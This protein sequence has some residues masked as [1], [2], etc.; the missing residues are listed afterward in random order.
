MAKV[1]FTISY[2]IQ[3]EKRDEYL[4][5]A[6]EMARHLAS[7]KGKNYSIYELKNK[8]NS[9]C[10]IFV[11]ASREEYDQLE[12]DQD[13]K[14]EELVSKLETLVDGKMKYSTMFGINEL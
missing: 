2:D 3:P 1:L 7:T 6:D 14:T 9:F 4:S 5:L 11:C 10:E 13:E 12:D 8:K